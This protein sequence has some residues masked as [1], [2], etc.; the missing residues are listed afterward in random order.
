MQLPQPI[1]ANKL[2]CKLAIKNPQI[3]EQR[4]AVHYKT[5]TQIA[6]A[7]VSCNSFLPALAGQ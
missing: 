7:L 4:Q 1:L 5:I 2:L 6:T 3:M